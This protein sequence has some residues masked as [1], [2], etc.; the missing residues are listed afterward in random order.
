MK[1]YLLDR[2]TLLWFLNGDDTLSKPAKDILRD[3]ENTIF[4]SIASLWEIGIKMSIG[5]LKLAYSLEE[6]VENMQL[7]NIQVLAIQPLH[8]IK[9]TTL[10]FHH[11][12]PFDRIII[13]QAITE[14]MK[15]ISRDGEFKKYEC[16]LIW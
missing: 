11:R 5:K 3:I 9:M 14:K 10:P 8:I 16:D 12:D 1:N 7:Q 4:V 2:H 13:A 15:L 6:I